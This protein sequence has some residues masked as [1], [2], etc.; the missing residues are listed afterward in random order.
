[1]IFHLLKFLIFLAGTEGLEPSLTGLEAGVLAI[2]HYAPMPCMVVRVIQ[3]PKPKPTRGIGG[4]NLLPGHS[5]INSLGPVMLEE[6]QL[7]PCERYLIAITN[8]RNGPF[9]KIYNSHL[10]SLMGIP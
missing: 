3:G 4:I 1:M 6:I 9:I 8:K 7:A 10:D 5:L 2:K